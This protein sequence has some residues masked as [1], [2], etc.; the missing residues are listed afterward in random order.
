MNRY[1]GTVNKDHGD[2]IMVLWGAPLPVVDQDELG[3]HASVIDLGAA[4]VAGYH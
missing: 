4:A 1:E 2:N 3:D